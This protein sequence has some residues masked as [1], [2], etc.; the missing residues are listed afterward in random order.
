MYQKAEQTKTLDHIHLNSNSLRPI[1]G[2]LPGD[3]QR[4]PWRQRHRPPAILTHR[5]QAAVDELCRRDVPRQDP[6]QLL[7][8]VVRQL[9]LHGW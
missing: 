1:S 2:I 4:H 9:H 3:I 7:Q 6:L 8:S 5:I